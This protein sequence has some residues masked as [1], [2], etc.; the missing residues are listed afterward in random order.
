MSHHRFARAAWGLPAVLLAALVV[1]G[2]VAEAA[3]ELPEEW[4]PPFRY[5]SKGQRDPFVPLVR[6]GRLVGV[7]TGRRV[8]AAT[9]FLYGVLWD[10]NGRSIALINDEDVRVGEQIAGYQVVEIREDAV[11]LNNGGKPVVLRISF[12]I[13][14]DTGSPGATT[15]GTHP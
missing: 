12:E 14:S 5:D 8:D 3:E 11:V 13:P 15:G 7:D 4:M 1:A 9:P 6:D 10:P 2:G